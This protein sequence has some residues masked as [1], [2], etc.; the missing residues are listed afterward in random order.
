MSTCYPKNT[1]RGGH[2]ETSRSPRR[3]VQSRRAVYRADHGRARVFNLGDGV[4]PARYER[5]CSWARALAGGRSLIHR[6][7]FGCTRVP[8]LGSVQVLRRSAVSVFAGQ[9][10]LIWE[11][12]GTMD[13]EGGQRV[14]HVLKTER[15][16]WSALSA[17]FVLTLGLM[18][19]ACSTA[20]TYTPDDGSYVGESISSGDGAVNLFENPTN[21]RVEIRQAG[22]ESAEVSWTASCNVM[23]VPAQLRQSRLVVVG[24]LTTTE[25][26]CDEQAQE[27]DEWLTEFFTSEPQWRQLDDGLVVRS[28]DLKNT[29]EFRADSSAAGLGR[30]ATQ[31]ASESSSGPVP[32]DLLRS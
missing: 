18:S 4:Q 11:T 21:I 13:R 26:E 23:S 29:I 32:V 20:D 8:G 27:Q 5:N 6:R 19:G 15:T 24:D 12:V 1:P 3:Y 31:T 14:A 17:T 22:G 16:C 7:G 30:D 25:M 28:E 2:A 9:G 10:L